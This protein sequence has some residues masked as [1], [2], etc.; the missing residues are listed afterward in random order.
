MEHLLKWA[1]NKVTDTTRVRNLDAVESEPLQNCWCGSVEFAPFNSD[2]LQC[3]QC[4]SLLCRFRPKYLIEQTADL[5]YGE[6]YWTEYQTDHLSQP[7][8]IERVRKDL[9]ERC[10]YW[11]RTLLRFKRPP[12][13][14]LE[15]GSAHGGFVAMLR[16]AGFD[17]VG[18]ELSSWIIKLAKETFD[19][20]LVQG[21][22]EPGSFP[23]ESFDAVVLL[24]VLEHLIDPVAA[25]AYYKQLLKPDGIL[26][27]QTPKWRDS[28]QFREMEARNDP[29]LLQLMPL[30][31]LCLFTQ[32]SITEF[33]NRLGF[34]TVVFL[35]A[36]FEVYDM[37]LVASERSIESITAS[38]QGLTLKDGIS[39]FVQ[40]LLDC[41]G[42][43]EEYRRERKALYEERARWADEL[44]ALR[45]LAATEAGIGSRMATSLKSH[46]S[47]T[48]KYCDKAE[49]IAELG[50]PVDAAELV[51]QE[52]KENAS[53][54]Q[55]KYPLDD[56]ED[57]TSTIAQI[58][59][60]RSPH[61]FPISRFRAAH[62]KLRA[63]YSRR[64]ASVDVATSDPRIRKL[65]LGCGYRM[66]PEWVNVDFTSTLPGVIALDLRKPLPFTD[67]SFGVVYHSHVL[68]HFERIQGR[69]FI[70]ECAR[71]LCPG[72]VLRVVVPDLEN[73]VREYLSLLEQALEGDAVARRRYEW[74]IVEL[75]D[76]MVRTRTGGEMFD[77]FLQ[78][79]CPEFEYIVERCGSEA[80][81]ARGWVTQRANAAAIR[82]NAA[83]ARTE[84]ELGRF[85]VSG[86][87][88]QWMY[89][90]FSLC[91]L[92]EESGFRDVHVCAADKSAIP[93]FNTF[94][95]DIEADGAVR[96]PGSLF[97][98]GVKAV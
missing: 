49:P 31:H 5:L 3:V 86:E 30:E 9:S 8:V 12:A 15:I 50:H 92:L 71:V 10:V 82:A 57:N 47:T 74:I 6:C 42:R 4:G 85:R 13:R 33:L 22:L 21:P 84:K 40:A 78:E 63:W 14:V 19:V 32:T 23:K 88:H 69:R 93:G 66:H 48:T 97:V 67:A 95:L 61:F 45:Q 75:M 79:P 36:L 43:E 20:D 73:V 80:L 53:E 91:R 2:Y 72:G 98:E 1:L 18:V 58:A 68:E 28:L 94:L 38:T 11:L 29:L 16:D 44:V 77:Y 87:V 34:R 51:D 96:I 27:I 26:L 90:R 52:T 60:T 89:D 24:D 41:Y 7:T 62:S 54:E 64:T 25:C 65:N 76:Q 59:T 83:K 55:K 56:A 39:P 17:A 35:P 81:N 37:F 46:L 70:M